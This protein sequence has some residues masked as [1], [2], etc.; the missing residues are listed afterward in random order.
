M[1][2][3]LFQTNADD[4]PEFIVKAISSGKAKIE[5]R[6]SIEHRHIDGQPLREVYADDHLLGRFETYTGSSEYIIQ[7]VND[8]VD[9]DDVDD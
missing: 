6:P 8:V 5:I 9:P 7:I 1:Y 4:V 2:E 3:S